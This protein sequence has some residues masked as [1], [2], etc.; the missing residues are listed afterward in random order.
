MK[1]K[2][3]E[4]HIIEDF[5]NINNINSNA[6]NNL[7]TE[8]EPLLDPEKQRKFTIGFYDELCEDHAKIKKIISLKYSSAKICI[9][10]FLNILT[11]GIINLILQWFPKMNLTV[12]FDKCNLKNANYVG[13][14]CWDNN[15][16]IKPLIK[17]K[18]PKL[19]KDSKIF[20]FT[21]I[22]NFIFQNE[23]DNNKNNIKNTVLI[24]LFEFK[25]F[26]Y[27]YDLNTMKFNAVV[28]KIKAK[29]QQIHYNLCNG[30]KEN[31]Y[32][33]MLEIFGKSQLN[34]EI[35]SYIKLLYKEFSDP[36]YLFQIFSVILWLNNDY[37]AYACVI[38]FAT[39]VSLIEAVYETRI[40]LLNLQEMAK[41]HCD[42][43]V[44][45]QIENENNIIDENN[46][47]FSIKNI[48]ISSDGL[49]PGD[50]FELPDNGEIIPC[51]CILLNGNCIMNES[52]LTG[53]SSP[54]FKTS[55]PSNN[56]SDFNEKKHN[57]HLL[58]FGTKIIQ[59]RPPSLYKGINRNLK[60][61][62]NN[63]RAM[64]LST[65]FMTIK[66]NLIRSIVYPKEIEF[67]FKKDSVRYIYLMA[68]LSLIGFIISLPFLVKSKMN[69]I[70]IFKRTLDL[71]TITVPPALPACIGIG[72]SIAI[73]R[74]ESKG[75]KCISRDRVNLAGKVNLICFDKTGTLTEEGLS[76]DG[77]IPVC[78]FK[79]KVIFDNFIVDCKLNTK[80]AFV[81]YKNKKMNSEIN[82]NINN[83][84][85]NNSNIND[86]KNNID[87]NNNENSISTTAN[88]NLNNIERK[89]TIK[90]QKGYH[91]K[92]GDLNQLYIECLATCHQITRVNS[93]LIGDPIDVK[94]FQSTGWVFTE[95]NHDD[96]I[97][98]Y[99]RPPQ[100]EDLEVK[101]N[102]ENEDEDK[103]LNSHYEIG[104]I[105]TF[106]FNSNLARMS[107]IVKNSKDKH[108]KVF[109]KGAPEKIKELCK[110]ESIPENFDDVLNKYTSKG[111]RVLALSCK[112]VK[113]NF[114]QS[115]KI[116]R[117]KV[118]NNLIFLGFLVVEN[119][120]KENTIKVIEEL[121]EAKIKMIMSTGDNLLTS[122]AVS[123]KCGLI[124]NDA[125]IYTW[126]IDEKKNLNWN[127]VE[128]Y[129]DTEKFGIIGHI[130]EI[131]KKI[132]AIGDDEK[133][134]KEV[135][136][137]LS[138]S[139]FNNNT[140]SK[141]YGVDTINEEDFTK[142]ENE[143][144][145]SDSENN[146]NKSFNTNI[147]AKKKKEFEELDLNIDLDKIPDNM[148][149]PLNDNFIIAITGSTFEQF[150]HLR[151]KYLESE[152]IEENKKYKIFYEIF[153]LIL[154]NCIIYA[155]MSPEHKT[156]LIQSLQG[157]KLTVCMCGD[158][159]NDCGAL[160]SADISLS[161]SPEEASIS[162]PFS[163]SQVN[164][165]SPLIDLFIEGKASLV[166][167]IQTF[168]YMMLYS[169]IQ[170]M[171]VT[172]LMVLNSYLSDYQ[173]L[174][175]DLVIIFP[176]AFLM[177]RT[178][179]E[180]KLT[181]LVPSGALISVPIIASI[182]TQTILM[183][184]FQLLG[185]F[186]LTK[187]RWYRNICNC[188]DDKVN[189]CYDNSVVFLISNFQYLISAVCFSI[190]KPF[191]KS[192]FT[193]QLLIICLVF[194][195][196]YS[197]YLILMP[198]VHNRNLL[199]IIYI[200][201]MFFKIIL[202]V[203][204]VLNFATC[205]LGEKLLVP[206]ITKIYKKI[207]YDKIKQNYEKNISDYD[208]GRLE[209]IKKLSL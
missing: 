85:I 167:S 136:F 91:D 49:V 111:F 50:I 54:I 159:A 52:M 142:S 3:F 109:C 56:T 164:D 40:N 201:S 189:L 51:D 24:Y 168:K 154:K 19:N 20:Q 153:R 102:K 162:A 169:L 117:E 2:E 35:P 103:I 10:I 133:S 53:E 8:Y 165:I 47:N 135:N 94:M 203:I 116:K 72:I 64:V 33:F 132:G 90:K 92:N 207:K 100:E 41:F 114:V 75:I 163:S 108:F 143:N 48:K 36:F 45:R 155:R 180:E 77:F 93:H 151:N 16:Y 140:F 15:F 34:I 97:S 125:T 139:D 110:I 161:L 63:L 28:F 9:F 208:L 18:V 199:N 57:K 134:N 23:N 126:K 209:K 105:K 7:L 95:G 118:E 78:F 179:T 127:L 4:L 70:N 156:L 124:Q 26:K 138:E 69:P 96:L 195:F 191:K 206:Y 112:M 82:N 186:L 88:N 122:I 55:L 185:W 193:N 17:K 38:I 22:K 12:L 31:E 30:L 115:Q 152:E 166:T 39:I 177:S 190:N 172:I 196:T 175:S 43:N 129:T 149:D 73:G 98:S 146:D 158:G 104:F 1:E 67:K 183:L 83:N 170:F 107:V 131:Y 101:L 106:E 144:T 44:Y 181:Y 66:G 84:I 128:N 147:M 137:N 46:E 86:N 119:N 197:I 173:F 171:S 87:N 121:H 204:I 150:Y 59:K 42:L 130:D 182:L 61:N 27:I 99:V 205:F 5:N 178:Q 65:S 11:L 80:R 198:D 174:T 21:N 25:M 74:L 76:I 194:A 6:N 58:Y 184:F 187:N 141:H 176:L 200:P 145:S 29:T 157:E 13:I 188:V 71:I 32:K 60:I 148:S 113:M 62:N 68:T 202:L 14:Y 160:K 120:L 192:I 123:K 89:P 37:K 81:H 79:D